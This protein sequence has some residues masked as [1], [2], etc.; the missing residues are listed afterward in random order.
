MSSPIASSSTSRPA[1]FGLFDRSATP[2]HEIDVEAQLAQPA[3]A[4]THASRATRV[5][6]DE[7]TDAIDDFFGA[8]RPSNVTHTCEISLT[9]TRDSRHDEMYLSSPVDDAS[10]MLPP[11]YEQSVLP[12][13]YTQVSDQPTLAMYLFKFG[14]REYSPFILAHAMLILTASRRS[15][16]PLLG[17]RCLHPPL[18]PLRARGLGDIEAR[19]RARGNHCVD[20]ARGD[21]MGAAVPRRARCLRTRRRCSRV[22][23]PLCSPRINHEHVIIPRARCPFT[24]C[25]LLCLCLSLLCIVMTSMYR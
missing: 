16:P 21:Q 17:S 18:A 1:F 6:V 2:S 13:A 8:S 23:C 11:P 10:D 25:Q 7:T 5:S 22:R 9:G 4:F 12:P 15:V 19:A 20:A 3:P 14:F 24:N